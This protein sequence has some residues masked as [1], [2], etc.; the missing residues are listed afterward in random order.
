MKED[1]DTISQGSQDT[2]DSSLNDDIKLNPAV[3]KVLLQFRC[4]VQDAILGNYIY[5]QPPPPTSPGVQGVNTDEDDEKGSLEMCVHGVDSDD[6][7]GSL[8]IQKDIREISLWGIPLLPSKAHEGTDILL[9]KFLQAKD[10]KV[11]DAFEMLQKMLKWR[12]EFDIDEI[13]NKEIWPDLERVGYIDGNDRKG[14]PVCYMHYGALREMTMY[15]KTFDSEEF[16][17][18]RAQIVEKGIEQLKFKEGEVNSMIQIS[19]LKNSSGSGGKDLRPVWKKS[20]SFFEEHYPEML[21]RVI[22]VNVPFWFY[23]YHSLATRFYTQRDK[24]KFVFAR[25]SKATKT[26]LKYIAPENLPV[27]YGG[28]KR[29]ND[30]DF[31]PEIPVLET[32][33]KPG[34]IDSIEIPVPEAGV[35]VVWDLMVV[36]LDVSY[37]EEFVP[38]DDCSYRIIIQKTKNLSGSVRNSFYINEPG[39]V[40]LTIDNSTFKKKKVLYRLKIKPTHPMYIYMKK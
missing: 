25:P 36:G 23:A 13:L 24:N 10:F 15:Q 37:K 3:E 9:L 8:A 17:R 29:D 33:V 34:C 6:E 1:D 28:L 21:H 32:I 38:D 26:L 12:K 30:D 11:N 20:Y 4:K 2:L 16:I 19:D 27:Q 18:W 22:F 39:N 35:T 14:R 40:R 5:G 7:N 31:S